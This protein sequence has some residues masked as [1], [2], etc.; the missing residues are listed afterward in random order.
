MSFILSPYRFAAAGDPLYSNVVF[1]WE[2]EGTDG[3]QNSPPL[4]EAKNGRVITASGT[5]KISNT[6]ARIGSTSYFL[7]S[8]GCS[9]A[10]NADWQLGNTTNT[11]QFTVEFSSFQG[12]LNN[13]EVIQIWD[14]GQKSWWLRIQTDG[15]LRL[16]ASADGTSTFS[17]DVTTTGFGYVAGAWNDVMIDK[18]AAGKIRFYRGGVMKFAVT[19]ANSVFFNSTNSSLI[20][21]ING[22]ANAYIDHIRFSKIARCGNDAGYTFNATPFPTS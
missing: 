11:S 13:Y 2:A 19:P 8:G 5:G 17:M 16:L 20:F 18:D 21:N 12:T 4:T 22:A 1:L 15:Q 10:P 14:G 7:G 9:L 3:Q 6:Q